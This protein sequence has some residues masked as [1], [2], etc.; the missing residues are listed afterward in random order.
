MSWTIDIEHIAGIYRGTARLEPGVNAVRGSNWQGKS[1]FI[2]AIKTALGTAETLTDGKDRGR[3]ELETPDR[4]VSLEL[5]RTNGS[6]QI[7][8]TPY[9]ESGYDLARVSLFACL[10]EQ[11]EIREA[12]RAGDSLKDGLLRPLDF[13]NIDEKIAS[14]KR[15]RDSI[16]AELKQAEEAN[17]RLPSAQERVTQLEGELEDLRERRGQLAQKTPEETDGSAESTQ[18][19]LSQAQADREQTQKRTERLSGTID[20]LETRLEERRSELASIEIEDDDSLESELAELKA[21]RQSIKRN[22]EV[23]QT[24]YSATEMVLEENQLDLITDV[25]REL[26]GDSVVC[27][28]CGSEVSRD[29]ITTRLELLGD[30]ITDTRSALE[31]SRETEESLEAKQHERAQARSRRR[32]LER[33]IDDLEETLADRTQ[34]LEDA[35]ERLADLDDRVESLRESVT[36]AVDELA[37]VESEIKYRQ[38]ELEH[39]RDELEELSTRAD[40]VDRLQDERETIQAEIEALRNRKAEI[41][42]QARSEFSEAIEEISDR[43][44]TGFETAHLTSEFDLVVARDGRETPIEALSEGER[45]LI[46]LIAALA[47]YESFDVDE[48][49]PVMLLDGIGSLADENLQTLVEYLSDRT[50]YLVFTSYPEHTAADDQLIDPSEWTVASHSSVEAE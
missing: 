22:L 21:E 25:N 33:E 11:N 46:G 41:T 28:T 42:Q 13:Q 45:E 27:W 26:A 30:R 19:E 4:T 15:E 24:V 2:E 34:G 23:L 12:V 38:T 6:V 16:D 7:T 3:V 18:A 20:R 40:Q 39:A 35:R 49:V 8:G 44:E 43:F 48:A 10:D 17:N 47:G 14:R 1:S 36:E 31:E 32:T 5:Q 50:E 37:D 29:E 9:L